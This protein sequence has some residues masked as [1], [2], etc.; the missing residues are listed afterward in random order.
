MEYIDLNNSSSSNLTFSD[1]NNNIT[2][3]VF[4]NKILDYE[5]N[6]NKI[7]EVTKY[8]TSKNN[9]YISDLC[10]GIKIFPSYHTINCIIDH[11]KEFFQ[12]DKIALKKFELLSKCSLEYYQGLYNEHTK[13]GNNCWNFEA[14]EKLGQLFIDQLIKCKD[15][16]EESKVLIDNKF[17]VIYRNKKYVGKTRYNLYS[18]D[19]NQVFWITVIPIYFLFNIILY[20]FFPKNSNIYIFIT[21][22]IAFIAYQLNKNI[23][24]KNNINIFN[25]N[26]D[27]DDNTLLQRYKAFVEFIC[28]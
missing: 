10:L 2:F 8:L 24:A 5:K 23:Y 15:Q 27:S 1:F 9:K 6:I 22:T 19:I 18:L 17:L 28:K 26:K 12:N 3:E 21:S 4:M 25:L 11:N 16:I 7:F 20:I 14:L 13:S